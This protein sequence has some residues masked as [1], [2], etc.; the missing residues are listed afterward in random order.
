MFENIKRS[1]DQVL[2]FYH[3]VI[4]QNW[5]SSQIQYCSWK[6][7]LKAFTVNLKNIFAIYDR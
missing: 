2:V 4:P 5:S 3:I 6:I 1:S 7:Q